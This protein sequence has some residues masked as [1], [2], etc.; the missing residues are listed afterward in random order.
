MHVKNI[1]TLDAELYNLLEIVAPGSVL[2]K[3]PDKA[4]VLFIEGQ[5]VN[6]HLR[7]L[8]F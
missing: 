7:L 3:N 4:D 1:S 8:L 5:T 6:N 2:S